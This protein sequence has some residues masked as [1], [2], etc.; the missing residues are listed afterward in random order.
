MNSSETFN[1]EKSLTRIRDIQSLLQ[2]GN[3]PF[4]DSVG[5]FEEATQLI[6]ACRS[7]LLE[8]EVKL[9]KLSE[10]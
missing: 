2:E 4:D 1:L 9:Q 6:N 3:Q 8:A 10:K 5:L 7:Y